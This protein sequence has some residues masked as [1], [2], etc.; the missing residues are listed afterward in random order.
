M[1]LREKGT[2][3]HMRVSEHF[4]LPFRQPE[5]D[6]VDVDVIGDTRVY[7]DPHAIRSLA[8]D[9]PS[10]C[11]SLLQD[12]FETVI[13]AIG[14]GAGDRAEVLLAGLREP[15]ETHLGLSKGRARGHGVGS[16]LGQDIVA[17]IQSSAAVK[18]GLLRDLEDA[19]L[20]VDHVGD[21]L[22]SDISTN[23][24]REP[25]IAYTQTMANSYGIPLTLGVASGLMWDPEKHEWRQDFVDLPITPAGPL[26]LV[27]KVIVRQRPDYWF[28]EYYKY[29]ILPFLEQ[30]LMR[31]GSPLVHLLKDGRRRIFKKDVVKKY[32][33]DKAA[34][35][36]ITRDNPQILYSY[37]AAKANQ[38]RPM[39][40]AEFVLADVGPAPEWDQLLGA[41]QACQPGAADAGAYH[42]AVYRLL[43][44]LFHPA[45]TQPV[46]ESELHGGLK[47]V[48]I[49]YTNS[50]QTGFFSWLVKNG[51][52]APYVA[53]ECKNYSADPTNPELDQLTGRFSDLRG[54]VGILV[55]RTV[56]DRK[57]MTERCRSAV[58][59]RRGFIICLDDADLGS[60][61]A[62]AASGR[63]T[64]ADILHTRFRDLVM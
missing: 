21:D 33:S 62:A 52:K 38:T 8:T 26:L 20:L 36:R 45:L 13:S 7:V 57:A 49:V 29:Y 51:Y 1:R 61:A 16:L 60:I 56:A 58:A 37:R 40:H 25:L 9:W 18:S 39:D 34:V 44:V 53:V 15:N 22:I 59:D 28:D 63:A 2:R 23:V 11:V 41:V 32:G 12:F 50:A 43:N 17:A 42:Q 47:R 3:R 31:Q 19:A 14:G 10:W 54:N 4:N 5:L 30:E 48:D 55:C 35:A 24:I 27:P 64:D 6:F 46:L